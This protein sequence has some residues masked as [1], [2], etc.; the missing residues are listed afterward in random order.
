MN[1]GAEDCKSCLVKWEDYGRDLV[2]WDGHVLKDTDVVTASEPLLFD[3][4]NSARE[5]S[6]DM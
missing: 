3:V 1:V 2:N 4:T 5:R 6:I